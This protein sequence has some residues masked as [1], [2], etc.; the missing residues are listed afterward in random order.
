M[1]M[2]SS[3]FLKANAQTAILLAGLA[4]TACAPR[5]SAPVQVAASNPTVTYQYRNDGDLLQANQNAVGFCGQYQASPRQLRFG[6]GPNGRIVE[7]ECIQ[8]P[9]VAYPGSAV[10]PAAYDGY[11]DDF[12]GP[13]YDGYWAGDGYF[14]FT[15]GPGHPFR[16]DDFRHFRHDMGGGFHGIR[17]SGMHHR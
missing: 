11:Y 1:T 12:Y 9:T 5:Y 13:F 17:G 2:T 4:V 6:E 8:G 10:A 16:R 7:F 14:Y 15:D 3:R